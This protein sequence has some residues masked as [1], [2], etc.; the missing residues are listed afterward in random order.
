MT[1][2]VIR[3]AARLAALLTLSLSV[4]SGCASGPAPIPRLQTS[5][6]GYAADFDP[7]WN[8]VNDVLTEKR[9]P[10]KAIEKESGLVT[11]EFVNSGA[12]YI[13]WGKTNEA[14]Q[15]MSTWAEKTRYFL[16]I[17]VREREGGGTTV[18]VLP[19]FEYMRYEYN[20]VLKRSV[21]AGWEACDSHGDVE[22]EVYDAL[23]AKLSR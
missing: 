11:T 14:G 10:I 23:A 19:H 13:Y 3:S 5:A 15:E 17:R 12:R 2:N 20:S 4:F 16:N 22:R 7:A 6:Q 1:Y 8:A 9:L 21:E 18:D